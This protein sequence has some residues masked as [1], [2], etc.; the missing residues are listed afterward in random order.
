MAL[1]RI[2]QILIDLIS[3]IYFLLVV[4]ETQIDDF[5]ITT[6]RSSDLSKLENAYGK[7]LFHYGKYKQN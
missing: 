5:E 7:I 1:I 4:L 6:F 2:I 3:F